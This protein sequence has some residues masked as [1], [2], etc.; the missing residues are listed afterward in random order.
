MDS[1]IDVRPARVCDA[2]DCSIVLCSSI[3]QLCTLDHGENVDIINQWVGNKTPTNL[4]KWIQN[5]T[6][7]FL[8]VE[9]ASEIAAVGSFNESQEVELNYVSPDHRFCGV[10]KALLTRMEFMIAES[11][12]QTAK[13]TS[14]ETAHRF[15]LS[16][17][18]RD[19]A[20]PVMWCGMAGY[21][22][23]KTL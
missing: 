3:R 12:A 11:G 15:Y 19:V 20:D 8:V 5:P 16:A 13:L 7:N 1:E 21:P 10:S 4:A 23:E 6:S 9:V 14:T 22:M 18:W 2:D 17:G